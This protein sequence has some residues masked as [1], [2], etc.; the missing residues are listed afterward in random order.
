V[1]DT[2]STPGVIALD[3]LADG[4]NGVTFVSGGPALNLSNFANGKLRF[5][6]AV[7]SYG[8]NTKGLA[9]KMES[10]GDGC[11]NIDYVL[12]DAIKPPAD[13]QF[14]TVTLDVAAV[15]GQKNADCFTL[16][17]ISV[18]FGIFPVWDDQQ[19]VSFKVRNIQLLQ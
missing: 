18:P 19:G 5:E 7:A 1:A 12:P 8:S 13:G 16:E 4:G 6:I 14:H 2:A 11:R 9:I 10:P 15:A 17:N 3:F